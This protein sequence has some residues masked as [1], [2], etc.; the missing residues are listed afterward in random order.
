MTNGIAIGLF[1]AIV[2]FFVLDHYVLHW[3]ALVMV[4]RKGVELIQL[5]AFW[6]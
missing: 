2:G 1:V 4:G 5:L 6:H 3:D